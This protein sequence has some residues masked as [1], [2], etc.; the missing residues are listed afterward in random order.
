[1]FTSE[2]DTPSAGDKMR[3]SWGTSITRA[4]NAHEVELQSLRQPGKWQSLRVEDAETLA[5]FAVRLHKTEDD[6]DGLWEIYLPPGCCNVG[7]ACE[8]LNPPASGT[9]GHEG[10]DPAWRSLGKL[11]FGWMDAGSGTDQIARGVVE[12]HVK[13]SAKEDGVDHADSPARRLV[14]ACVRDGNYHEYIIAHPA[15]S[16]RFKYRDTAG[17]SFSCDV[18]SITAKRHREIVDGVWQNGEWGYTVAQLRTSPVDLALP[19]GTGVS[20][21]DLVW[22]LAATE[23]SQASSLYPGGLKLEVK[24]LLCLRQAASAAGITITGDTMTDVCGAG[25]ETVPGTVYARIDVTDLGDG[26][27]IVQVLKDPSGVSVSSPYVVWLHLYD[28]FLNTVTADH[29]AQS[30]VNLQLFHA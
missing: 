1:M 22:V 27:G 18:A 7:G 29:R 24:K 13:T 11:D 26:A 14:W 4:V 6:P 15:G 19:A 5:P 25:S 21:F 17:D 12:I 3:A 2:I 20:G 28:I 10:D 16:A 23:Q 30:L 8:P 9:T